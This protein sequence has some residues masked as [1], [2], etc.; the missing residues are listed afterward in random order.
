LIAALSREISRS[1]GGVVETDEDQNAAVSASGWYCA[2][3]AAPQ[4]ITLVGDF[5]TFALVPHRKTAFDMDPL[6]TDDCAMRFAMAGVPDR[7]W[8]LKS[9]PW[10][11]FPALLDWWA[12]RYDFHEDLVGAIAMEE[13]PGPALNAIV[14]LFKRTTL[15]PEWIRAKITHR[16]LVFGDHVSQY[17]EFDGA[18]FLDIPWVLVSYITSALPPKALRQLVLWVHQRRDVGGVTFLHVLDDARGFFRKTSPKVARTYELQ[19]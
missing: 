5:G 12:H 8:K 17:G 9:N 3:D 13:T 6:K 18:E 16:Y 14:E 7:L 19:G 15:Q 10:L 4:E 2:L 1:V 11:D